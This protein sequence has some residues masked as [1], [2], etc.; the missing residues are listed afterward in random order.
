MPKKK[1]TFTLLTDSGD[2]FDCTVQQQ[3]RKAIATTNNSNLG[4]YIRKRI[5]VDAGS[6]ITVED[7]ERYGRTDF[8]LSKIDDETFLFDMSV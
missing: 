3:N 2:T 5:G 4:R 6:F 8:V 1:L 7:L